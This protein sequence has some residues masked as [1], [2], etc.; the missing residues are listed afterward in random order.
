MNEHTLHRFGTVNTI[1]RR[2]RVRAARRRVAATR[3][4]MATLRATTLSTSDIMRT[5]DTT[6]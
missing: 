5:T 4:R 2:R 6:D 3:A 1:V